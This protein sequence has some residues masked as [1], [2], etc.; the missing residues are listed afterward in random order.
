MS[1]PR[2]G[3]GRLRQPG[4]D[5]LVVAVLT[6]ALLQISGLAEQAA[7]PT[8][9]QDVLRHPLLGNIVGPAGI[10]AMGDAGPRP[11]DPVGRSE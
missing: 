11:C 2:G 6:L 8:R 5:S 10:A 9:V 4:W 1:A 7:L 3:G